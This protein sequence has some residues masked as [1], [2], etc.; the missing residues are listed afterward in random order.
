M[1]TDSAGLQSSGCCGG[2]RCLVDRAFLT[3]TPANKLVALIVATSLKH[4]GFSLL[5]VFIN[6]SSCF[7]VSSE[8]SDPVELTFE[9]TWK[10]S[11][12]V[13]WK[14]YVYGAICAGACCL[15]TGATSARHSKERESDSRGFLPSMQKENMDQGLN[16][17]SHP[18]K[19]MGLDSP[20]GA[21][22]SR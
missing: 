19:Y 17:S 13:V 7:T 6:R 3:A 8:N 16:N 12:T 1:N 22:T 11:L 18:G 20:L 5:S 9:Q 4:A 14:G 15:L 2:L 21:A 10:K